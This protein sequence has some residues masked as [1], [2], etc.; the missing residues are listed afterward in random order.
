MA[1]REEIQKRLVKLEKDIPYLKRLHPD[2]AGFI[3][4]FAGRA[5]YLIK[6]A[7]AKDYP[8]AYSEMTRMLRNIS[9]SAR[10][11]DVTGK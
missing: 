10:G 5:I 1:S 7:E 3:S 8:W 11:D 2:D 4:E 9:I 6:R